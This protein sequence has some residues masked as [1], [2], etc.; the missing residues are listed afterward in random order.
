MSLESQVLDLLPAGVSGEVQVTTRSRSL[1]RFARSFIH[2]NVVDTV[3]RVRVR[4]VVDGSWAVADTDRTDTSSLTRAVGS[5]VAAARLRRP[6]PLFPGLAPVSPVAGLML[7][8]MGAFSTVRGCRSNA[9]ARRSVR[10]LRL[11]RTCRI[12]RA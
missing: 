1:T 10:R 4:V 12:A 8:N 11:C 6:D 5:A 2:Q 7:V 9:A 3:T